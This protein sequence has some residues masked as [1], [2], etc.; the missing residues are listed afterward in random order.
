MPTEFPWSDMSRW[1]AQALLTLASW[2]IVATLAMMLAGWRFY[3]PRQNAPTFPWGWACAATLFA[4]M[5][6]GRM[7]PILA[8]A[9][10]FFVVHEHM[11]HGLQSVD[12]RLI[13]MG[14]SCGLSPKRLFFDV[15]LGGAWPAILD[16]WRLS[17]CLVWALRA[18]TEWTSGPDPSFVA[19]WLHAGVGLLCLAG[20]RRPAPMWRLSQPSGV[21]A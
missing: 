9:T 14:R 4:A 12:P 20:L 11:R 13:D 16:G 3:P 21:R 10:T 18:A 15:I 19:G 1:G 5:P 7:E 8:A 2:S 17:L 6:V